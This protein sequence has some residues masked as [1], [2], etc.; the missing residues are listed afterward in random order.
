MKTS[1]VGLK[2]IEDFEGCILS[3]YDDASDHIVPPGGKARG[4]LT[5]GYGHTNAAGA[6]TVHPG[7]TITKLQAENILASDLRKVE[8]DVNRLVKVPLN[9]NQFDALVSFHFNTGSLARASLLKALNAGN[10][11]AAANGLMMYTKG[12]LGGQLVPMA[13]LVRRRTAEKALFLKPTAPS[14][15]PTV[16]TGGVVVA[17]GAV[18]AGTPAHLWPWVL[19][20]TAGLAIVAYVAYSIYE[21][22]K[23][24]ITK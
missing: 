21:Y 9:Q 19:G 8:A 24:R 11:A 2:L 23:Q 22:R 18:A 16:A 14:V 7:Q 10:Y 1:K 4:T 6:P 15:A 13:G 3:A 20:G 5:I 17:G 12:R